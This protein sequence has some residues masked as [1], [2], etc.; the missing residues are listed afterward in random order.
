MV[1]L[2]EDKKV[3]GWVGGSW[4]RVEAESETNTTRERQGKK[5]KK[6]GGG[7]KQGRQL[8]RIWMSPLF[9]SV[10]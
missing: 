9:K 5:K 6:S 10:K 8:K 3:I 7:S 1:G 4:T 2:N